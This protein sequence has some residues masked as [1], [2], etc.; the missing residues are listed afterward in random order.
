MHQVISILSNLMRLPQLLVRNSSPRRHT[1][2]Q[3]LGLARGWS[4][5]GEPKVQPQTRFELGEQ[6]H[7][8]RS[9]QELGSALDLPNSK[10]AG[11]DR[12]ICPDLSQCAI[13][14]EARRIIL[15]LDCL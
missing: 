9:F 2:Q 8:V 1:V 12:G 4:F 15:P 11:Q 3:V 7:D 5:P 13:D 14:R 10:V 6:A